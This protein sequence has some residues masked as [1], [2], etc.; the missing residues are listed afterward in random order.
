M[1]KVISTTVENF[2]QLIRLFIAAGFLSWSDVIVSKHITMGRFLFPCVICFGKPFCNYWHSWYQNLEF[3]RNWESL[4][5]F[6]WFAVLDLKYISSMGETAPIGEYWEGRR[7]RASRDPIRAFPEFTGSLFAPKSRAS[8]LH[9][10]TCSRP[11]YHSLSLLRCFW[12]FRVSLS[13][14][15]AEASPHIGC[16]VFS[17]YPI[18]FLCC[19]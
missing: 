13:W 14:A 6:L 15:C 19:D 1:E 2:Q 5:N 3:V 17:V 9:V 11:S 4:D 18:Q 10:G 16:W 12:L 7:A 8:P